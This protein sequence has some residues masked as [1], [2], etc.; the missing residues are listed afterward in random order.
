M[1]AHTHIQRVLLILLTVDIILYVFCNMHFFKLYST[2]QISFCEP[3]VASFFLAAEE[4]VLFQMD[5]V[6]FM[7]PV[8]TRESALCYKPV[9]WLCY[10]PCCRELPS[11]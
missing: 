11:N 7:V 1:R 2:L 3:P 5:T 9:S 4:E 6:E 10:K 8:M